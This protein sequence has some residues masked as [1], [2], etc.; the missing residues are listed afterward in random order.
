MKNLRTFLIFGVLIAVAAALGLATQQTPPESTVPSV[1]NPGALGLRALYLYLR[2]GGAK[3]EAHHASLEALPPGVRTVVIAAP[4]A[5]PI[6][7]AEVEA[8]EE[9]Y[10]K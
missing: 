3:V 1:E 4:Q 6:S 5:R 8:L 7:S 2:E 9:K 10:S